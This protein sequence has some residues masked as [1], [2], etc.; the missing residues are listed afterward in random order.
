MN[1]SIYGDQHARSGC[2]STALLPAADTRPTSNCPRGRR[3]SPLAVT[4]TP[5]TT[6]EPTRRG[7]PITSA[8]SRNQRSCLQDCV[9][10]DSNG[11]RDAAKPA[12]PCT[13]YFAQT[14]C[15]HFSGQS[16]KVAPRATNRD[17]PGAVAPSHE[18]A[19]VEGPPLCQVPR[20]PSRT[21]STSPMGRRSCSIRTY[22]PSP[23]ARSLRASDS[24]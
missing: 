6:D 12:R 10:I 5:A 2:Q 16:T 18:G 21:F 9:H 7:T 24:S 3:R 4:T 15:C 13:P 14:E 17:F 20:T 1:P 8:N 19:W 11:C 22:G 23:A